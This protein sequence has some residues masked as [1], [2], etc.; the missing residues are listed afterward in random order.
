MGSACARLLR[1]AG[2]HLHLVGRNQERLQAVA[3]EIDA[4]FTVGD[5]QDPDLFRKVAAEADANLSG[6]IYAVGTIN[7]GGFFRQ[8][9]DQ[10]LSDFQVNALGGA[11]AV[12]SALPAMKTSDGT[13]SVVFFSSVAVQQGFKFHSSIGMAKGAVEG[14]TRSL[15]AEL[16]PGIR[17]NAIAPSL[18][19]TPLADKILSNPKTAESIASM[20]PMQRLGE[21]SD[22]ASLA[23]FLISDQSSWITGQVIGVDGGRSSLSA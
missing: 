8:S 3:S 7:L 11:L 15:A 21:A 4:S 10:F 18:T 16:S 5:V 13:A 20:H 1:S 19:S 14:L 6:L 22:V 12:Q 2:Y 9:T 17:V 23:A